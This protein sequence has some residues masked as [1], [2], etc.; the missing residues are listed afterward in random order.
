M[1]LIYGLIIC[2]IGCLGTQIYNSLLKQL[3]AFHARKGAEGPA[4]LESQYSMNSS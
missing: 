2:K 4:T 3:R 1:K